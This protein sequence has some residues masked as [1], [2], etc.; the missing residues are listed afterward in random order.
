MLAA[1][2]SVRFL[3]CVAASG[4]LFATSL[5]AST[6]SAWFTRSWQTDDGL[7]DNYAAAVVQ[8]DDGFLWV[9]TA[10]GLQRFDGIGFTPFSFR[11]GD[12]KEDQ[13]VRA[14]SPRRGGG[15]WV[16]PRRGPLFG[17]D[18]NLSR[19]SLP[20]VL[21]SAY[22]PMG[23]VEDRQG[24]LWV[25]YANFICELKN[26]VVT[27]FTTN[28]GVPASG[29]F[30][31]FAT[32]A[33]NNIWLAKGSRAL[34]FREGLFRSFSLP[35][36]S[37]VVHL[38]GSRS[39]GVWIAAGTHLFK[40]N[41]SGMTQDCGSFFPDDSRA[42][43]WA[44]L[45]DHTGAVWL[46]TDGS[47][48]FRYDGSSF[49]K[50]ETSHPYILD[51][52]EDREGNIWVG[53]SGGGLDRVGPGG[54]PLESFESGS[55]SVAIQ[56]IC[57]DTNGVLWGA[58]Q[59]GL[60]VSRRDGRWVSPFTNGASLGIVTC[61]A[62]DRRGAVWIGS[63]D[64]M[65][66]RWYHNHLSSWGRTNHLASHTVVGLLPA[67]NGDL[68]ISLYGNPSSV[69]RMD[70]NDQL[71]TVKLPAGAGRISAMAEDA[72]GK[73]WI[74]SASGYLMQIE[75]CELTTTSFPA[76]PRQPVLCLYATPDGAVWIGYDAAG[77]GRIKNGRLST[78]GSAQGL[79]DE[80]I[81]EIASDDFGWFWFGGGRGIFKVQR[82]ELDS[83]LEGQ[84]D[85]VLPIHYGRN[86]GLFSVEA[87]SANV[88]P[89]VIPTVLRSHDGNLWMPL[90]KQIAVIDPKVLR[91]KPFPPPAIITRAA[92]DNRTIAE[93]GETSQGQPMVNLKTLKKPLQF[94]PGRRKIEF[95]FT[96]LNFS[97]PEGVRFRYRLVGYDDDWLS[98]ENRSAVYSGLGRGNYQFRVQ[99]SS[100]NGVWNEAQS[101]V[102]FEV[103]PFFWETWWFRLCVV[104]LFTTAV[105]ALA[106]YLSLRRLR[107]KLRLVEQQAALD[108]ERAR[109]ARDLH[110]DL[111]CSLTKAALTLDM[112]NRQ[113]TSTD[114]AN[115]KLQ[116]CSAMVRQIARS[117]DEIVWAINPRNDTLRYLID[118]IS[119]FT[120]EFLH[121]AE[122]KCRV[123]LPDNIPDVAV[124]P[125]ARHN[126]F[127]VVKEA[128]NNVTRHARAGEV[129]LTIALSGREMTMALDDNGCGFN[130]ETDNASADGLRNMRQRMEE[131]GGRFELQSRP[132]AGTR[133]AFFCPLQYAQLN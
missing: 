117:V 96:A 5:F 26:G 131:L 82:P 59:N 57:E 86:E 80:H 81:S 74:G 56:S 93:Y 102:A 11:N 29:T 46:G 130:G 8:S 45:E 69:Q 52:A 40:C 95:E 39:N 103:L 119:Q 126:L 120:V 128:L 132:G 105:I 121:A 20:G 38:A 75:P 9:G 123:D 106:R 60:L 107:M 15:L 122:I 1:I 67:S 2:R 133:V 124:S 28:S 10:T 111:G 3:R 71:A 76:S 55:S 110:D 129:H 41:A 16:V 50:I 114:E 19:S 92:M 49:E 72:S 113:I 61:V 17:L 18:E 83:A 31:G 85:R 68:W 30:F 58:T 21:L 116:N 109:I 7:P 42:E 100:G 70:A 127:L 44:L 34:V 43:A 64:R 62:A 79:P 104:L 90:R 14:L 108:K 32:D 23:V 87:N 98:P 84:L 101:P 65:L 48:L 118:Y 94:P 91:E 35:T 27:Q 77:L 89:F 112:T 22:G 53:T 54:V 51:V 47:G 37:R 88:A 63:R 12:S 97:T 4:L 115:G 25:A 78:I 125:E 6:N 24:A 66:Q 13:G 36:V 73:I 33:E 99:A